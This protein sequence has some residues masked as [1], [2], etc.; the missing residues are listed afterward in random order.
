MSKTKTTGKL[1]L[2]AVMLA[3]GGVLTPTSAETVRTSLKVN[4]KANPTGAGV[5]YAS[6]E[7]TDTPSND[8][9]TVD[10]QAENDWNLHHTQDAYLYA[11]PDSGYVFQGWTGDGFTEDSVL[12]SRQANP[13]FMVTH[14]NLTKDEVTLYTYIAHFAPAGAL[15]AVSADERL[16]TVGMDS[17]SNK[18]GD[19]VTMTAFADLFAGRFTG[20][21]DADSNVVSMANPWTLTVSDSAR[22]TAQFV[23][24][25]MEGTGFYARL[26]PLDNES[27]P[28]DLA[29]GLSGISE[30][31]M[32]SLYSGQ[33]FSNS[34]IMAGGRQ[35]HA[36]PAFVIRLTGTPNG[37][38]GLSALDGTV[39]GHQL[40][41]IIRTAAA[42]TVLGLAK[43]SEHSKVLY[44]RQGTRVSYLANNE[45][46]TAVTQEGLDDVTT[47]TLFGKDREKT[48][49]R[50]EVLPMT[51][52]DTT[53]YFGAWP[54]SNQQINERYFTTMYTAFPYKCLDGVEAYVVPS[55]QESGEMDLR[56]IESGIVPKNTAVIL[57]CQT[58]DPKANR[59]LPLVD[60]SQEPITDN[61]LKG[62]IWVNDVLGSTR[63]TAFD[64][65]NMRVMN[66]GSLHFD[67]ET[68]NPYIVNNTAYLDISSQTV[69]AESY[70]LP[71]YA[72]SGI[73]TIHA[74]QYRKDRWH[75]GRIYT[76]DGCYAGR[77]LQRL[78]GG[79]YIRNGKK[80]AK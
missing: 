69:K 34:L 58:Q 29:L 3:L 73:I 18:I 53:A 80:I 25:D 30:E 65:E 49:F 43:T 54:Q 76:L 15:T 28:Q 62:E 22:Y 50:W 51:E 11:R 38:G 44:L 4:V 40:T 36:S 21:L 7:K 68:T 8:N 79:L 59:L 13:Y 70:Y 66:N 2:T 57:S 39:Q 75:N 67:T 45:R 6:N 12:V 77:D 31:Q 41:D 20:W 23:P 63:R 60:E 48:G 42:G 5:V 27:R 52:N 17:L 64:A 33:P 24:F 9:F 26:V 10:P 55:V 1:L 61:L 32:D 71:D 35:M 56:K 37:Y 78:P 19:V 14:A 46:A 16:G 47:P 74:D 72:G